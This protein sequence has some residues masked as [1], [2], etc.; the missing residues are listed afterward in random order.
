MQV[1]DEFK[2]K[3]AAF[4][5]SLENKHY[6]DSVDLAEEWFFEMVVYYLL[7]FAFIFVMA[8]LVTAKVLTYIYEKV[9]RKTKPTAVPL[10]HPGSKNE[11]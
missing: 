7:L 5:R 10:S 1:F 8:S 9:I 2:E 11:A 4:D 3:V 6:R